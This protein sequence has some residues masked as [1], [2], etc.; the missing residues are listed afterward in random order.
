[1]AVKGGSSPEVGV[2]F[3]MKCSVELGNPEDTEFSWFR[4]GEEISSPPSSDE[5]TY[6]ATREDDGMTIECR[7][8]NGKIG[9]G[10]LVLDVKS[11]HSACCQLIE[12]AKKIF[13]RFR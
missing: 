8:D 12:I 13:L 1:M 11:T 5:L 3:T 7:A 10:S 9:K 4:D 6:Q 2:G